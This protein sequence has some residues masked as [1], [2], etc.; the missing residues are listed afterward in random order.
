MLHRMRGVEENEQ[1]LDELENIRVTEHV[2]EDL[3]KKGVTYIRLS[4]PKEKYL[5]PYFWSIDAVPS[6][7]SAGKY[8]MTPNEDLVKKGVTYMGQS[9]SYRACF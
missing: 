8:M 6:S 2:P 4:L 7:L 9:L 3:V 1:I 5:I